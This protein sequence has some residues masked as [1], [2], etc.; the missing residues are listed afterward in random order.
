[1]G[2]TNGLNNM[3]KILKEQKHTYEKEALKQLL[4]E[5]KRL[6]PKAKYMQFIKYRTEHCPHKWQRDVF[7][8][9]L[10]QELYEN[11]SNNR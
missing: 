11:K 3:A 6:S 1:M 10:N 5:I 4:T 7:K 9:A 2:T 8:E